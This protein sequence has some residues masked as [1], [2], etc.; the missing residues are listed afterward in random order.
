MNYN[1]L[2]V[3]PAIVT[4]PAFS[5]SFYSFEGKCLG[6]EG[7]GSLRQ[8][9]CSLVWGHGLVIKGPETKLNSLNLIPVTHTVGENLC[10]KVV[11]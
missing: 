3:H 10:L 4:L 9:S 11:L 1:R 8:N 6:Q 7:K 5:R 2:L